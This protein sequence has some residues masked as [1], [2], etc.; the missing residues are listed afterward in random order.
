MR[1]HCLQH[2]PFEGPGSIATWLRGAGVP[3]T[4]TRFYADAVLP[5]V[6]DVDLLIVL[7][8]P[9]SVNDGALYPWLADELAFVRAAVMRD[10]A[11][12]GV[13]LG[14]QLIARALGARVYR[15]AEPEI[16]WFPITGAAPDQRGP[17]WTRAHVETTVFHWHGET[18]DLP[19]GATLLARSRGCEHQAF[20]IGDRVMGLQF[21]LET[22]RENVH[23]MVPACREDIVASRFVQTESELLATDEGRFSTVNALMAETLT[24][25]TG[26][27]IAP[28]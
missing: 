16:G 7:G 4:T 15:N 22:T 1:A 23:A 12:L 3:L 9:M 11:V 13:C 17:S 19:P 5:D 28:T 24:A 6:A 14:A 8:G 26:L 21:H 27:H 25:I 20:R 2:V 10:V 18:F